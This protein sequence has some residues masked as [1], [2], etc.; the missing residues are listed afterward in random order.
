MAFLDAAGSHRRYGICWPTWG[1]FQVPVDKALELPLRQMSIRHTAARA[2]QRAFRTHLQKFWWWQVASVREEARIRHVSVRD[3]SGTSPCLSTGQ[4]LQRRFKLGSGHLRAN[5]G[6]AYSDSRDD[7]SSF[8]VDDSEASF[9]K[10]FAL[11][12]EERLIAIWWIMVDHLSPTGKEGLRIILSRLEALLKQTLFVG[13][14]AAGA[15]RV[16]SGLQLVNCKGPGLEILGCGSIRR[17]G[18][19]RAVFQAAVAYARHNDIPFLIWCPLWS[20]SGEARS[21]WRH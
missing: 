3:V 18:G 10:D 21:F 2:I 19:G 14:R 8:D 4:S 15:F 1:L 6:N 20:D 5:A 13:A 9:A 11:A 7:D 12:A 17:S 16:F